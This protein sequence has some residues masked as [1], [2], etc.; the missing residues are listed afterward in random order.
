MD[1]PGPTT[2]NL[3]CW[4]VIG[5]VAVFTFIIKLGEAAVEEVNE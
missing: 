3:I 2:T 5:L 1:D 4:L